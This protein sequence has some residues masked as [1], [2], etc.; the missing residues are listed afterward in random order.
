MQ[1]KIGELEATLATVTGALQQ[2]ST[3]H[4]AHSYLPEPTRSH[5][6]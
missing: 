1:A 6:T 4:V 2:L 5:Q 3:Q